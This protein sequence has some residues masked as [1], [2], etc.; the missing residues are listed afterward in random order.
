MR[1]E[2]GLNPQPKGGV[3][4]ASLLK[5]SRAGAVLELSGCLKQGSLTLRVWLYRCFAIHLLGKAHFTGKKYGRILAAHELHELARSSGAA[6]ELQKSNL[7]AENAKNAEER[8]E[9][10]RALTTFEGD[11]VLPMRCGPGRPALR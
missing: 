9:A 3:A 7:T 2:Q 11:C 1:G 5:E 8:T 10:K 4:P 6:T